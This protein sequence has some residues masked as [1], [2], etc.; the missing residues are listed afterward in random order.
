MNFL[1]VFQFFLVLCCGETF[2]D[3]IRRIWHRI[4]RIPPPIAPMEVNGQREF[5]EDGNTQVFHPRWR[6]PEEQAA[7]AAFIQEM[8]V[9]NGRRPIAFLQIDNTFVSDVSSE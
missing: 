8:Y 3:R 7:I 2:F 9:R 5:V 1:G 4:R 6:S